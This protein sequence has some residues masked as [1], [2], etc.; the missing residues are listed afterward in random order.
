[1]VA[2]VDDS[3]SDAFRAAVSDAYHKATHVTPEIYPVEAAPGAEVF[4]K[5]KIGG[6]DLDHHAVAK[7]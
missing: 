2:L 7:P 6:A 5:A 1:M 3:R 4:D